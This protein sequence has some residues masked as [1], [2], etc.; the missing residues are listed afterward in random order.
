MVGFCDLETVNLELEGLVAAAVSDSI[1]TKLN[2]QMLV[3]MIHPI[4]RPSITFMVASLS[5]SIEKL[6]AS[7]WE[8]VEAWNLVIYQSG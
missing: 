2:E 1:I 3:F 7:V 8:I 4:F 6:Y 5:L